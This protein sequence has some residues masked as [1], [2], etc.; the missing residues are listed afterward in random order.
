[1]SEFISLRV[2]YQRDLHRSGSQTF[3]T[4]RMEKIHRHIKQD[5]IIL[6]N[7]GKTQ[8]EIKD[9]LGISVSVIQRAKYRQR[10]HG[11]VEGGAKKRGP[12][13]KLS[14]DLEDVTLLRRR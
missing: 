1:M 4:I 5:A 13:P 12:K 7:E 2:S 9:I 14:V 8:E 10:D 3:S 6:G 11:D